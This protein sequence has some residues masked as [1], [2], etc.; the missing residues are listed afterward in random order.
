MTRRRLAAAL[1]TM[2]LLAGCSTTQHHP[3]PSVSGHRS[4]S[5]VQPSSASASSP[6][7]GS[8]VIPTESPQPAT[9]TSIAPAV[10]PD[11]SLTTAA[12]PDAISATR[13]PLSAARAWAIAANS[14]SYL[15][16]SPGAW[17]ARAQALVTGAEAAA[18]Q[19]QRTGGGGSTWTQIQTAK[20]V[21]T[22][23]QLAATVPSDAPSGPDR[24]VV[25]LT[26]VTTLRCATGQVQ[27][28][29]FAAQLLLARIHGRWLVADVHH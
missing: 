15:D 27:L 16:P 23:Q 2:A 3:H 24:R 7:R 17:T 26:A 9:G 28:S 1:C 5:G 4:P 6:R 21:T 20:C 22:V 29:Q 25:Y 10:R 13:T 14:S 18:E 8:G 12:I 11:P 19:R